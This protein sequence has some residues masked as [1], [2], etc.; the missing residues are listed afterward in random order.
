MSTISKMI[1]CV[2]E[3]ETYDDGLRTIE[4]RLDG[5]GVAVDFKSSH[6]RWLPSASRT[7]HGD[8]P[9]ANVLT[10]LEALAMFIINGRPA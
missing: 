3:V 2:H 1:A 5:A 4:A 7:L 8:K 10:A 9:S 6:G